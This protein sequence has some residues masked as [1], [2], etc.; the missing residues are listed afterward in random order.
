LEGADVT[1]VEAPA[2][3]EKTIDLEGRLVKDAVRKSLQDRQKAVTDLLDAI[4]EY[5]NLADQ[6][7]TLQGSEYAQAVQTLNKAVDRADRLLRLYQ[8]CGRYRRTTAEEE[9]ARR[10]HIPT[11]TARFADQLEHRAKPRRPGHSGTILKPN[12]EAWTRCDGA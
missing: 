3:T 8:M 4:R 2:P 12:N 10:Y 9:L 11:T 1:G 5:R 7:L 6:P